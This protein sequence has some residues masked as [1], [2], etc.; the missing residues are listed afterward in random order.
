MK[1]IIS[2]S[3]NKLSSHKKALSRII[4]TTMLM[5]GLSVT[6]K[7]MAQ[8]PCQDAVVVP[9]WAPAYDHAEQVRYY[10]LPDV[11]L[12]YDV[13]NQMFIHPMGNYWVG[14]YNLPRGYENYDLNNAY[15]VVLSKHAKNPW[16]YYKSY[17]TYYP[18]HYY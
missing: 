1:N 15:V 3:V 2:S 4:I 16:K 12:F 17:Y 10:Y 14:S 7:T 13:Y 11:R 5:L 6:E 9:S 8:A 18:A